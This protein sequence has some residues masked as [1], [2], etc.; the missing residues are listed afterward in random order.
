MAAKFVVKTVKILWYLVATVIIV[1]TMLISV[2]RLLTPTLSQYQPTIIKTA[3]VMIGYP[4]E[5]G[6]IEASWLGFHPVIT[7]NQVSVI[8]PADQKLIVQLNRV[9]IGVS[10]LRT[11]ITQKLHTAKLILSGSNVT[12]WKNKNNE[13]Y[14]GGPTGI[15]LNSPEKKAAFNPLDFV[16]SQKSISLQHINL[17]LNSENEKSYRFAIDDINLYNGH[18]KHRLFGTATLL[19]TMDATFHFVFN[20]HGDWHKRDTLSSEI[21]LTGDQLP[22]ANLLKDHELYGMKLL[23]G[24]ADA[25]LWAYW[26]QGWKRFQTEVDISN[27]NL[28]LEKN[29]TVFKP[30]HLS[31]E[32][33]WTHDRGKTIYAGNKINIEFNDHR[34]PTTFF[35]AALDEQQTQKSLSIKLGDVLLNDVSPF[36]TAISAMPEQLQTKLQVL[37]PRGHINYFAG[38]FVWNPNQLLTWDIISEFSHL[39]LHS[40]NGRPSVSGLSGLVVADD[41]KGNIIIS[42]RDMKM[43]FP[44]LF[45]EE[46]DFS[47]LYS[48]VNWEKNG[49]LLSINAAPIIAHNADAQVNAKLGIQFHKDESPTMQLIATSKVTGIHN[50]STYL[51]VGTLPANVVHWLDKAIVSGDSATAG[52]VLRGKVSDFPYSHHNGRF[53]VKGHLTNVLL[54]YCDRWPELKQLNGDYSFDTKSMNIAVSS[55]KIYNAVIPQALATIPDLGG[56]ESALTVKGKVVGNTADGMRFLKESPLSESIGSGIQSIAMHGNLVVDL[57]LL[58]PLAST[59]KDKPIEVNGVAN[60][61]NSVLNLTH[62][63]LDLTQ[64]NGNISFTHDQIHS[65]AIQ[66]QLW[67]FPTTLTINTSEKPNGHSNLLVNLN[68]KVSAAALHKQFKLDF[69]QYFSGVTPYRAVLDL[70]SSNS[71]Q[72]GD[73]SLSI[74]STLQGIKIN[75]P[76]PLAKASTDIQPFLLSLHFSENTPTNLRLVFGQ[77]LS[78]ALSFQTSANRM[79]FNSG[80]IA[81]GNSLAQFQSSPGLVISGI[82]TQQTWQVWKDYYNKQKP[83]TSKTGPQGTSLMQLIRKVDVIVPQI[84]LK[85]FTLNQVRLVI[86][87]L[88]QDWQIGIIHPSIQ[89]EI[90]VPANYPRGLVKAHFARI[91]LNEASVATKATT[92]SPLN[93]K[94]LPPLQIVSDSTQYAGKNFGRVQIQMTPNPYGLSINRFT[95]DTGNYSLLATG[96]WINQNSRT[97]TT[98]KGQFNS[99]HLRSTLKELNLTPGLDSTDAKASFDL[100]WVGSPFAPDPNTL[101]GNLLLK[102]KDGQ[103]L[104]IS[105]QANMSVGL[106]RILNLFNFNLS[107]LTKRLKLDFSDLTDKGYGFEEMHGYF[108]FDQG[109]AST[110]DSKFSGTVAD[111]GFKGRIGYVKKDYDLRVDVSPELTSSLPL[112]ATIAGGPIAGA[113]AWAAEQLLSPGLK[114]VITYRFHVTGSWDT[115]NVQKLDQAEK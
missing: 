15:L 98:L 99:D 25:S 31:G 106:G 41:A 66:A 92:T 46:L 90:T 73:N 108:V 82:I 91:Q 2:A 52:L 67:N 5:I 86:N 43:T 58:I 23:N 93:P 38:N 37:Q 11:L 109:S 72:A 14:L 81:I 20:V 50:T 88:N 64:V 74:V 97:V 75:L 112:V 57:N 100:S 12:I 1:S 62:W 8:N 36:F 68:G 107:T 55:G 35:Y 7:L 103:I 56:K 39:S 101:H 102:L 59:L 47:E 28:L 24:T 45:R 89:G 69:L 115:P 96:N 40:D 105:K 18:K 65:N 22:L 49:D 19:D 34:W 77:K 114:K 16:L 83:S 6:S 95:M 54:N 76:A 33:S 71:K 63:N 113:A 13:Y 3:T 104:G 79:Q 21:Y 94:E 80:E 26:H 4:I 27:L 61:T 17:A 30:R 44:T 78:A 51:P 110:S 29:K 84:T 111:V 48:Q 32:F 10:V 53:V 42:S 9:Y 85:S 60:I 87:R 70:A